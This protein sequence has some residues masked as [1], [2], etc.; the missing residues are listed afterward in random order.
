[1]KRIEWADAVGQRVGAR[2]NAA[3]LAPQMRATAISLFAFF[4]FL[5][6]ATGP[7]LLGLIVK[8]RGYP[9]A[10]VVAGVGLFSTALVS[11]MLFARRAA[12]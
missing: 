1:M 3:E 2:S 11:R 9:A 10:F 6:Q 4:F 7:Q 12:A 8:S 5:G